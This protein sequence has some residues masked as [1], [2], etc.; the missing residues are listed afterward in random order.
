MKKGF[1]KVDGSKNEKGNDI[2]FMC[3]LR[4]GDTIY[5]EESIFKDTCSCCGKLTNKVI[6]G[7]KQNIES[8]I[9]A[10]CIKNLSLTFIE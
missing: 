3:G 8:Y 1:Y 7:G 10:S 2:M 9:G 5:F 4:S 6:T